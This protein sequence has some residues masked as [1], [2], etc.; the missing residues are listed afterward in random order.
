MAS[1]NPRQQRFVAAYLED[2]DAAN[3][4]RK[5]GYGAR[6]AARQGVRLLANEKVQ[7]AIAQG[8]QG[9]LSGP[10]PK[11]ILSEMA[12]MAFAN[13]ADFVRVTD[14][15]YADVDL[16]GLTRENAAAIQ[17][18]VVDAYSEGRGEE[19]RAV[20]RVRLK[21]ADKK[22]VLNMLARAIG[23]YEQTDE[24]AGEAAAE[25]VTPLTDTE[26]AHRILAM[27]ARARK[28]PTGSPD[29]VSGKS[30]GADD[31]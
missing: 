1:L 7:A 27:L 14:D 15:G 31:Q 9:G 29:H 26:R 20:K 11:R 23:L 10:N 6:R 21:L 28:I 2:L 19:K 8:F 25:N 17:E 3:A 30:V 13:M 5:A 12:A 24:Q 16:N 4:A 22:A 18:I